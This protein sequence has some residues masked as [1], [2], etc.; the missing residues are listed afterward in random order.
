MDHQGYYSLLNL[1]PTATTAEIKEAYRRE[2][3]LYHPDVNPD[4]QA[5]EIYVR[6]NEA[7][8]VLA[9]AE[10][11]KLYDCIPEKKEG[12][13]PCCKCG[14][15]AKQPRFIFFSNGDDQIGGV[16]CRSCAS[17][18]QFK[19]SL[20]SWSSFLQ[21][22][23]YTWSAL[24]NNYKFTQM[25]PEKNW[26]ILM[27]NAEAF[28]HQKRPD[29]ARSLGEQ[30]KRFARTE[31]QEIKT[32]I[33]LNA[34]PEM[35]KRPESDFWVIKPTDLVRVYLPLLIGFIVSVVVITTPYI[36]SSLSPMEST[37]P[38]DYQPIEVLPASLAPN[39]ETLFYFTTAPQ[40]PGYQA[41]CLDC[42]IIVLLPEKTPVR[43][44]GIVPDT[45]WVQVRTPGGIIAYVKKDF[46]S[47]KTTRQ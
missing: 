33:F 38:H 23:I 9:N 29:L 15:H 26:E 5:H 22:P 7:Y 1:P 6:L 37:V 13:V 12:F 42:G 44:T 39:D 27:Q 4:P 11:R 40:T 18:E 16:Y 30:A 47:R 20:S 2:V 14:R 45:P 8:H 32:C 46:L 21:K 19:S 10:K 3:K 36:Q 34:L 28:N 41:P 24:K 35:T 25:P 43:L 31:Q 17:K